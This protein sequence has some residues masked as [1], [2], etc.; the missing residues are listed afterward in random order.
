MNHDDDSSSLP[1]PLSPI[2][3]STRAP[4]RWQV[5]L[6]LF[7][8]TL[9]SVLYAGSHAAGED[10]GSLGRGLWRGWTFAVPLLS[11][12]LCHEFGHY[13]AAR[14]HGV[15]AS[16]PYFLPMPFS[17]FGTWGAVI[18]MPRRI[19]SRHALLDI[20][21]AGPLAGLVVALPVLGIGLALSPVEPLQ[22][23][24]LLE[25]QC[26]LYLIM[27]WLVV[28]VIPAGSDVMLHPVAFAGWAG[29]F[30]TMIN[31]LPVGQL[32]GG[33]IAY[34]LVGPQQN[35][36]SRWVRRSLLALFTGHMAWNLWGAT[37][38]APLST[39]TLM[40]AFSNS[41]FW[42]FWFFI[43]SVMTRMGKQDHP[44]TDSEAPLDPRRKAIAVVCLVLFALLFM[45]AP[46]FV[47]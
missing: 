40:A 28:G 13:L 33:H 41:L 44:P 38:D 2:A 21:A 24:G 25:G 18:S 3:P 34:A 15:P 12:L 6:V 10:L 30:V 42:L 29:L 20:G 32:D 47:Y 27:K 9:V 14:A 23:H 7:L 35:T 8:V 31:L 37:R 16:L 43:L 4:L 36:V 19:H 26:L 1:P 39:G 5:P 17:P 22:P 46:F 45:P 11:I